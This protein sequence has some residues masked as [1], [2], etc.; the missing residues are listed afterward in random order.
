MPPVFVGNFV[1]TDGTNLNTRGYSASGSGTWSVTI[2][3]NEGRLRYSGSGSYAGISP[4]ITPILDGD[5]LARV[6]SDGVN[7]SGLFI[8]IRGYAVYFVSNNRDLEVYRTD[9]WALIDDASNFLPAAPTTA[10]WVRFQVEGSNLRVKAWAGAVGDEPVGWGWTGTNSALTTPTA[11]GIVGERWSGSTQSDWFLLNHEVTDLDASSSSSVI[12]EPS[13]SST[14]SPDAG[15]SKGVSRAPSLSS[16]FAPSATASKAA[17]VVAAYSA[18]F[19]P[20]LPGLKGV[21]RVLSLAAEFDFQADVALPRTVSPGWSAGF[22]P[23]VVASK[24]VD[25][26]AAWSAVFDFTA[27]KGDPPPTVEPGFSAEFQV[28]PTASKGALASLALEAGFLASVGVAPVK[29]GSPLFDFDAWFDAE[30]AGPPRLT[31]SPG[32]AAE[33]QLAATLQA[34]RA[35]SPGWAV[36][37]HVRTLRTRDGGEVTPLG[38]Q[39]HMETRRVGQPTRS[40][41]QSVRVRGGPRGP[42]GR[43]W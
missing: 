23:S 12:V 14:F 17:A 29:F 16:T 25:R 40:L 10:C 37:F 20:T 6:R 28:S 26:L 1:G 19:S 31:A 4:A 30:A 35:V 22:V 36:R 41:G 43:R 8:E 27:E 11:T 21:A 7:G 32:F 9:T 13:F 18:V 3:S 24:A 33:F 38:R 5:V 15:A 34:L 42:F 2:Q 39:T